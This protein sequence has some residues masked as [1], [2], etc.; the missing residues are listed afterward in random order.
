MKREILEWVVCGLIALV[1]VLI[2]RYFLVSP[3]I[4]KQVSM[5]PTL[6]NNERLLLNRTFRITK[7]KPEVGDIVT[8]QAPSNEY[9]GNNV[10]Q[11]NPVGVYEN[12][13]TSIPGKIVYYGFEFGKTSYIKRVI[14]L[15]GS[16]VE[17]KDDGVF[18]DG[19]KLEEDYLQTGVKTES[20]VFTDFVVPEGY[21]FAMGDN[22]EHSRDCR[23]FGCI[24]YEKLE[25]I[26]MFRFWPFSRAGKI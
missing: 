24:P 8:F 15:E 1:I 14:A 18:V 3:T 16:H 21:F 4:V 10:D 12:D 6:K 22:R 11:S 19:V 7:R 17:I 5:Y 13:P 25:G 20:S 26:V 23:V 9:D 2:G